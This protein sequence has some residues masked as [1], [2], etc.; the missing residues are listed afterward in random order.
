MN[1]CELVADERVACEPQKNLIYLISLPWGTST[2]RGCRP[3]R[4]RHQHHQHQCKDHPDHH[5][6]G[7]GSQCRSSAGRGNRSFPGWSIKTKK[8][9]YSYI[10]LI[11]SPD[12]STAEKLSFYVF[13]LHNYQTAIACIYIFRMSALYSYLRT[14]SAIHMLWDKASVEIVDNFGTAGNF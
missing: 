8:K 4:Q 7:C 5:H 1:N 11:D 9:F 6:W 13:A 2:P 3:W 10:I 14:N 12:F